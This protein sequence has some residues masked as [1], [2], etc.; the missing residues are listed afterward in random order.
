LRSIDGNEENVLARK[1]H[2]AVLD[3]R[4]W[5]FNPIRDGVLRSWSGHLESLGVD[6][7]SVSIAE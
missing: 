2:K 5:V 6:K 7:A 1:A 3:M 4:I